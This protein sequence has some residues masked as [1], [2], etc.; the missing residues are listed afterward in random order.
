MD[1]TLQ[2]SLATPNFVEML[3][4]VSASKNADGKTP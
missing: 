1:P 3:V 4:V 2:D